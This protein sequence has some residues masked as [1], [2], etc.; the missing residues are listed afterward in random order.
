LLSTTLFRVGPVLLAWKVSGSRFGLLN[1]SGAPMVIRFAAAILV[2]DFVR[3]AVHW[4]FHALPFL[5]RVH[6]VHHSDPD[7]DAT[8]SARFHPIETI[9]TQGANLAAIAILAAPPAAVLAVEVATCIQSFFV[10]AN[11]A[12]PA[13]L[14]RRLRWM[15]ITPGMHRIHH[16]TEVRDQA[17]NFGEIFPWWDRLLK[18]YLGESRAG[19][20][21]A[22]GLNEYRDEKP[23]GVGFML[24]LPFRRRPAGST[25]AE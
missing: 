15:L 8:T 21:V 25:T 18:T 4:S 14:E 9:L 23:L 17:T 24:L 5:W 13:S 10:H 7:F 12:L 3:Y 11:V 20:G 22:T 16:S 6:Q 1:R 2:L 19:A